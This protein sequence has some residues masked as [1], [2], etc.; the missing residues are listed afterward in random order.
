MLSYRS[1]HFSRAVLFCQP[2]QQLFTHSLELIVST[3]QTLT[4]M[5][6]PA[7]N[8]DMYLACSSTLNAFF[9]IHLTLFVNTVSAFP[10][11]LQ[12]YDHHNTVTSQCLIFYNPTFLCMASHSLFPLHTHFG[13]VLIGFQLANSTGWLFVVDMI[14]LFPPVY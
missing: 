9:L 12:C 5:L 13:H 14:T 3:E 2:Y 10:P 6:P 11:S 1:V 7:L 8:L 4:C